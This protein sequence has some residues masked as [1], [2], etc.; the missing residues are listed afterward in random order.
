MKRRGN[1][2]AVGKFF[3]VH[4]HTIERRVKRSKR[5][6]EATRNARE[7]LNDFVEYQFHKLIEKEDW[8]AIRFH[9][10]TQ[11]RHRGYIEQLPQVA[12]STDLETLKRLLAAFEVDAAL[13][14][15]INQLI[16]IQNQK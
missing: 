14:E 4:R 11:M 12:N 5:L 13:D 8:R 2:T 7:E 16:D 3:G 10:A 15:I 6:Q 9:L 1:L